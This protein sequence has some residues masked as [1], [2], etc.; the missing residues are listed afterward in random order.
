MRG[1][2]GPE[3]MIN[4]HLRVQ[5]DIGYEHFFN[6][7]GVYLHDKTIDTDVIVPTVGVIGRL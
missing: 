5:A 6:V 2:G 1:G 3:V 4:G 7:D